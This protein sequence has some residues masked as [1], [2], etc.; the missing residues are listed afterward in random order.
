MKVFFCSLFLCVNLV[1]S[2]MAQTTKVFYEKK[3]QEFVIYADNNELCPVSLIINL[4]LSNLAFS[5]KDKKVFV[6]PPKTERFRIGKLTPV[7]KND[8]TKF[9]YNYK[10]A[11]GDITVKK[12]DTS[13]VYDLPFQKG[14]LFRVH[15]GYNGI[16][17]HQNE[18]AIDFTMPEGTEILAAREGRVVQIVQNNTE[19][20]PNEECK[21]YNN[22]IIIMHADGTF[23]CYAHIKYN[24]SKVKPGDYIQK[25]SVIGYSGNVGWSSGP[26]LHFAC[27]LPAFD[28]WQTLET[29]FR[30]DNGENVVLLME[31]KEY[32][33]DY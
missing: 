3:E 10:T 30:I 1:F 6:I 15:Q 24:G 23:G 31:G 16:F 7:N 9:S 19:S 18:K 17:S 14:N 22:H 25:G 4:D 28:K 27:F 5:D 29:K 26:H 8:G 12:Y 21:K 2:G 11:L 20:C 33:R 13:F 32:K